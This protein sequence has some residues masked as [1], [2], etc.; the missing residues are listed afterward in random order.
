MPTWHELPE[1]DRMAV[2]AYV[3]TF[4]PRWAEERPEPPIVIGEPP[5][6][7]PAL[8]ARG[9]ALYAQAKCAQCHGEGGKGDGPSA[10]E[11][12][13]DLK[14]R[15]RPADFTRGQFKGGGDVR[16]IYRAMTSGLDGTPMP[17]FA[18][19]MTD[20]ERWAISFYVL[21]FSAF[22]DPLTGERLE[23]DP[24]VKTRLNTL[25]GGAHGTARLA[26]DPASPAAG[27]GTPKPL[28]RFYKGIL[29]EGR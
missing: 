8:L 25:E 17:S 29:G 27:G 14:F 10:N 2:I 28:V 5:A 11:L 1:K 15:I 9:K 13:D 21:S 18:D 26:L 6:P 12:Q 19:A 3:K 20:D 24:A 7:T 22:V 23:L 16:D 4:S